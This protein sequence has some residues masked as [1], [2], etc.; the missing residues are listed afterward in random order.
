MSL[1]KWEPF[2]GFDRFFDDQF[3]TSVSRPSW[4]LAVD[5]YEEKGNMVAR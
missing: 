5:V 4:D 1:I 2:N 3:L